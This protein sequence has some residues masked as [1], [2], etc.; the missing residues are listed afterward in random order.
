MRKDVIYNSNYKDV[1]LSNIGMI[2]TTDLGEMRI[3]RNLKINNLDIVS[4]IIDIIKNNNTI[5]YKK[6]KNYYCKMDNIIIT[7]NSYNYCII[8]V[9]V[10]KSSIK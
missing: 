5:I 1:L 6:G 3:K 4:H 2:H 10:E 7:I 9:H 8:T